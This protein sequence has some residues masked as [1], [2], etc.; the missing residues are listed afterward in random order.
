MTR[1]NRCLESASEA[2]HLACL[3]RPDAS[4]EALLEMAFELNEKHRT[5][6]RIINALRARTLYSIYII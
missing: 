2:A 3:M 6:Y 1:H 5:I 4:L